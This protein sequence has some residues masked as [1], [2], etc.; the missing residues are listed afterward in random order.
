MHLRR[1]ALRDVLLGVQIAI[2]TL[3]VIS[4]LVAVR[5]MLGALSGPLGFKPQGAMLAETDLS[6]VAPGNDA[7]LGTEKTMMEAVRSLPGV[8]AVGMTKTP[9][10]AAAA[11]KASPST[12][13]ERRSLRWIGRY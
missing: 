9:R 6:H 2:C 10:W 5:G 11:R 12:G 1:F 13:R 8:T 4:S 3:L 7:A